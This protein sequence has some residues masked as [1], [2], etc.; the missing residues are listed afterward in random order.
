MVRCTSVV[1]RLNVKGVSD[2]AVGG[3]VSEAIARRACGVTE[4]AVVPMTV[5]AAT[6]G[7]GTFASALRRRQV[8]GCVV[9]FVAIV[10]RSRRG[11]AGNLVEELVSAAVTAGQL[12]CSAAGE[13][14]C[15]DY[16]ED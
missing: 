7:E 11:R 16:E 5:T 13:E 8:P 14:R 4:S 15:F 1:R 3:S 12:P 2:M 9:T 10:T 6:V